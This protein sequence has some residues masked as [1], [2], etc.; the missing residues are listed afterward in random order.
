VFKLPKEMPPISQN[1][2]SFKLLP[3]LENNTEQRG[4][5]YFEMLNYRA[6]QKKNFD[7]LEQ[8]FERAREYLSK[9]IR[10]PKA[11]RVFKQSL[12]WIERDFDS[13]LDEMRE[14]E[15]EILKLKYTH[16]LS[17][18]AEDEASLPGFMN[19]RQRFEEIQGRIDYRLKSLREIN[20]M[21]N[22]IKAVRL[23]NLEDLR[24]DVSR[25]LQMSSGEA[26]SLG[27]FWCSLSLL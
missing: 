1:A 8:G 4:N 7:T 23:E 25:V 20:Q 18:K 2:E 5:L 9:R 10:H 16:Q 21:M 3:N 22:A 6:L 24:E 15:F 14:L 11:D 27:Q 26:R 12:I 17:L 19:F 13:L